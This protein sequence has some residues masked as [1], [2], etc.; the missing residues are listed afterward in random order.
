[1]AQFPDLRVIHFSEKAWD[2]HHDVCACIRNPGWLTKS[3]PISTLRFAKNLL[4]EVASNPGR[5]IRGWFERD[6][7]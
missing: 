3:E 6:R 5:S 2:H 1:V 7:S 4:G